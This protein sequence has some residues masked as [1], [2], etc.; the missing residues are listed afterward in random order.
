MNELE[1]RKCCDEDLK[2]LS[3]GC[4]FLVGVLSYGSKQY[5]EVHLYVITQIL[6]LLNQF[7]KKVRLQTNT[8]TLSG[9]FSINLKIL[10]IIVKII[11][12]NYALQTSYR[13]NDKPMRFSFLGEVYFRLRVH[14]YSSYLR[15]NSRWS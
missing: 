13:L 7:M 5:P 12:Y 4:P 3:Y 1:K 2:L 6:L 8:L 9:T 15:F 11:Q 10:C 14:D